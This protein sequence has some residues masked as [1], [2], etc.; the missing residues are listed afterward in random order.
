MKDKKFIVQDSGK[1]Q[2]FSTGSLRDIQEG[3]GRFDL[4]P[5]LPLRRLAKHYELG[6]KKYGD[7]NWKK[8]QPLQRY[9]DSANRHMNNLM[10]GEPTEDH[11]ISVVW[12][13][14]S[15]IW[16]LN[17]IEAGRLPKELDDRQP[18]EPQYDSTLKKD[19]L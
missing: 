4:L 7:H 17:E 18:P 10:A 13:M 6:A 15:Y 19:P 9:I 12:N 3:K 1:R 5:S 8:G 14:F 11:A 2:E 16:T